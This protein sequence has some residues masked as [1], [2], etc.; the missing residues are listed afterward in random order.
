MHS[1][2]ILFYLFFNFNF[3]FFSIFSF[4]SRIS[5]ICVDILT[6]GSYTLENCQLYG[7]KPEAAP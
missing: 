4:F 5:R 3:Q 7:T 1:Y 2:A 6:V